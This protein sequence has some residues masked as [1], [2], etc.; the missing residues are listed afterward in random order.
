[1]AGLPTRAGRT[2]L[3][4]RDMPTFL[5]KYW[6]HLIA[7]ILLITALTVVKHW[8]DNSVKLAEVEEEFKLYKQRVETS[9]K[10]KKEVSKDFHEEVKDLRDTAAKQPTPVVRMCRPAPVSDNRPSAGNND[11]APATGSIPETNDVHLEAGPDLGPSLLG[12]SD[13]GDIISARLRACQAYIIK[14]QEQSK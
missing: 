7:G 5:R 6:P 2:T 12:V 14:L 10:T 4:Q 9:A 3:L 1:L 13:T 8:H 11:P